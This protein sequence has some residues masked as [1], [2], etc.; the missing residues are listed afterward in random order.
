MI[1]S[2]ACTTTAMIKVVITSMLQQEFV[3]EAMEFEGEASILTV[4]QEL[5][6]V[7][8]N[9]STLYAEH[10]ILTVP[11]YPTRMCAAAPC[12]PYS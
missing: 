6:D 7:L 8:V 12:C 11:I 4:L 5:L 1:F 9:V 3:S 10:S 2:G